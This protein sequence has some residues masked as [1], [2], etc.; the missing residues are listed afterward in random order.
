MGDCRSTSKGS[1][2]LR[3]VELKMF[4]RAAK[5]SR[6]RSGVE[7]R[8]GMH[9]PTGNHCDESEKENQRKKEKK[10]WHCPWGG[11]KGSKG[12]CRKLC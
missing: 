10:K 9:K 6:K 8:F 2:Q 7:I 3:Y 1:V 5:C 12:Y 11:V 4:C